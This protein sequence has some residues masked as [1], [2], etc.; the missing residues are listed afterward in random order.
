MA[1][2]LR[3]I[4]WEKELSTASSLLAYDKQ[5]SFDVVH[6]IEDD[7]ENAPCQKMQKLKFTI[8]RNLHT[9]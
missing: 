7:E 2:A 8:W 4:K 3:K 5:V 1:E 6:V 9:P